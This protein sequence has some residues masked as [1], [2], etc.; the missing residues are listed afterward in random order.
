M[1][2]ASSES[3]PYLESTTY[4]LNSTAYLRRLAY[5]VLPIAQLISF[6]AYACAQGHGLICTARCARAR[7]LAQHVMLQRQLLQHLA[8][9]LHVYMEE[10]LLRSCAAQEP[11]RSGGMSAGAGATGFNGALLGGSAS[12]AQQLGMLPGSLL[13]P[14]QSFHFNGADAAALVQAH[15]RF[16]CAR[17]LRA[18]GMRGG[19]NERAR[20]ALIAVA[21]PSSDPK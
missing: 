6:S 8:A 16:V 20:A 9:M 21:R 11:A 4:S 13:P 19:A 18:N 14:L 10:P 2:P 1:Q 7:R 15:A 17:T 12:T 5:C 3:W